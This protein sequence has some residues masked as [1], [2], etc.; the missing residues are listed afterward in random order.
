MDRSGIQ[1]LKLQVGPGGESLT[2]AAHG[3]VF[4]DCPAQASPVW[5]YCPSVMVN[6]D[7]DLALGFSGGSADVFIGAYSSWRLADGT[8]ADRP[9]L[10][11]AG[12][13]RYLEYQFGDYSATVLDPTDGPSFWTVQEFASDQYVE[14]FDEWGTLIA[15]L[16]LGP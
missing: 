5:Y 6:V 14:P 9:G 8:R 3:R 13:A 15:E 4:D 2:Y 12:Q 10:L 11:Q 1:W 16:K 7:G